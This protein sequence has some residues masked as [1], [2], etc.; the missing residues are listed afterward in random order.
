MS[1]TG[2]ERANKWRLGGAL[3]H[4]QTWQL[5]T[6]ADDVSDDDGDAASIDR[7][8]DIELGAN[9][10]SG[11]ARAGR[12]IV[13]GSAVSKQ[14]HNNERVVVGEGPSECSSRCDARPDGNEWRPQIRIDQVV[15]DATRHEENSSQLKHATGVGQLYCD[16]GDKVDCALANQL[17]AAYCQQPIG[18][19]PPKRVSSCVDL[20]EVES[21]AAR[22]H[23]CNG[24]VS[25]QQTTNNSMQNSEQ[26]MLLLSI[27][28]PN[29]DAGSLSDGAHCKLTKYGRP[30]WLGLRASHRESALTRR[31]FESWKR[32]NKLI[33]NIHENP[34]NLHLECLD[35]LEALDRMSE[36]GAKQT[37]TVNEPKSMRE[38]MTQTTTDVKPQQQQQQTNE[39]SNYANNLSHLYRANQ[40]SMDSSNN[41]RHLLYNIICCLLVQDEQVLATSSVGKMLE[42][43]RT[44]LDS[45][46]R[47]YASTSNQLLSNLPKQSSGQRGAPASKEEAGQAS[48]VGGESDTA[49]RTSDRMLGSGSSEP[50]EDSA[51]LASTIKQADTDEQD[52]ASTMLANQLTMS[53]GA[54][55]SQDE[56]HARY[57]QV[58]QQPQY[59]KPADFRRISSVSYNDEQLIN[60]LREGHAECASVRRSGSLST[61]SD[62]NNNNHRHESQVPSPWAYRELS[63]R[64]QSGVPSNRQNSASSSGHATATTVFHH[65]SQSSLEQTMNHSDGPHQTDMMN[66]S[67]NG[68]MCDSQTVSDFAGHK[69]GPSHLGGGRRRRA[70]LQTSTDMPLAMCTAEPFALSG[71]LP[72]S[73][74]RSGSALEK[75]QQQQQKQ[76]RRLSDFKPM[77]QPS[78]MSTD[79][80]LSTTNNL[81]H[82][83][84]RTSLYDDD[85]NSTTLQRCDLALSQHQHQQHDEHS[86]ESCPVDVASRRAELE[87]TL[88][89]LINIEL[90]LTWLTSRDTLR[91]AIR[92]IGVPNEIRG[93][94]WLILFDQMIGAK[95]DVSN[96]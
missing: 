79:D 50:A 92:K 31:R 85:N 5:Q 20:R 27:I 57:K 10:E 96:L 76:Q 16:D 39:L 62:R 52:V 18:A 6:T 9:N 25:A 75:Q 37:T 60:D 66:D 26:N 73:T 42:V 40:E 13:V 56:E 8:D 21:S 54:S 15:D 33:T 80:Y 53:F 59:H 3:R 88:N 35:Q 77:Q 22:W 69:K 71:N 46:S 44:H 55:G 95:Y 72:E 11:P 45:V 84:Q 24:L 83:N 91:R 28:K 58:K 23:L 4:E 48:A 67:G 51:S 19:P 65:T 78:Y 68:T 70:S 2:A 41:F 7:R 89:K 90:K 12:S 87:W 17:A 29:Q 1:Y 34:F 81:H 36:L 47:V 74:R 82:N 49:G 93:K 14:E 32:A 30:N 61:D 94:V 86:D 38:Q 63:D 64:R 43:I